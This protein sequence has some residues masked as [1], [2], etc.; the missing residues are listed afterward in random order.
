MIFNFHAYA[1]LIHKL[2]YRRT[3]HDNIHVRGYKEKGNINTPLELAILNQ[4]DRFNL[5]IDVIDRVPKLAGDGGAYRGVAEGP[6]YRERQLRAR[7]RDRPAGDY[8]LALRAVLDASRKDR[9]RF[10]SGVTNHFARCLTLRVQAK[11]D[12]STTLRNDP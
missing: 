10:H 7:E 2:T 12:S 11:T 9:G 1:S 3:N 5:A 8:R 6:D 4:V